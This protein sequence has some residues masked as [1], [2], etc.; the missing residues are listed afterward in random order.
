MADGSQKP[1][2]KSRLSNENKAAIKRASKSF[3]TKF[4][5]VIFAGV[6]AAVKHHL[7]D[8]EERK[9]E[10]GPSKARSQ[11]DDKASDRTTDSELR[12]E[13]RHLK[14]ALRRKERQF[15][16]HGSDKRSSKTPSL[17]SMRVNIPTVV[18][19]DHD[20]DHRG[21]PPTVRG[22]EQEGSFERKTPQNDY[23]QH[24]EDQFS[25]A[26]H[27]EKVGDDDGLV[28]SR[29]LDATSIGPR[30]HSHHR[31]QHLVHSPNLRHS[32]VPI[33][34]PSK[35]REEELCDKAI[36]ASKVSALTGAIEALAISDRHGKWWDNGMSA[37]G[38]RTATAVAA[39]FR[40]SWAR[41]ENTELA[42]GWET[43]ANVGRGLLITRIVHGSSSRI[44]EHWRDERR[45]RRRRRDSF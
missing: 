3:L 14:R 25:T 37:K 9:E 30:H 24:P 19:Q 44:D 41:G 11:I 35:D 21:V 1:K 2:P 42:D 16:H 23:Y 33:H 26:E 7:D 32:S 5:P 27:S 20:N 13:V 12:R 40:T 28:A 39:G 18:I 29:D 22:L 6:A 8:D 10:A 15:L 43:I 17:S 38:K 31:H 36:E 4:G 45:G 34:M